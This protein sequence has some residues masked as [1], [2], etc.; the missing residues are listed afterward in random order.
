M[1]Y[2]AITTLQL[3]RLLFISSFCGIVDVTRFL[4]PTVP[5]LIV[6]GSFAAFIIARRAQ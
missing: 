2:E 6:L 3:S 1:V 4:L 5:C